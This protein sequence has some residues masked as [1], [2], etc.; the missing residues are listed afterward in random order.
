[1]IQSNLVIKKN[2]TLKS[3]VSYCQLFTVSTISTIQGINSFQIWYSIPKKCGKQE[4]IASFFQLILCSLMPSFGIPQIVKVPYLTVDLW[5]KSLKG[6]VIS[7]KFLKPSLFLIQQFFNGKFDCN[8]QSRI[9][10]H[11]SIHQRVV[12]ELEQPSLRSSK[13]TIRFQKD[14]IEQRFQEQQQVF[15]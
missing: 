10:Y 5:Y 6:F 11:G 3:N 9:A 2:C 8:Y 15:G 4:N 12:Q 1:M 14:H 13:Q 7:K